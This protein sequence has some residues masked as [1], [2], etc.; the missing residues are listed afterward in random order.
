MRRGLMLLVAA[1]LG[2]ALYGHTLESGGALKCRCR[3]DC[4]CKRPGL[5]LFRWVLPVGHS[6]R[7]RAR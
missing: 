3:K 5:S 7:R 1:Y 4:W 2:A 6:L